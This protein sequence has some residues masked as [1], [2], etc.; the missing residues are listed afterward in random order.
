MRDT[1]RA[2]LKHLISKLAK[3]FGREIVENALPDEHKKLVRA[4]VKRDNAR[5]NKAKLPPVASTTF[6]AKKKKLKS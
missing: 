5:K 1:V 2:P 6:P 3:K 4:I